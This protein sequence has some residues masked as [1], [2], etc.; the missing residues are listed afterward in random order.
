MF[1]ELSTDESEAVYL[2]DKV[3]YTKLYSDRQ[4]KGYEEFFYNVAEEVGLKEI[5]LYATPD[6]NIDDA[7]LAAQFDGSFAS[8]LWNST[9]FIPYPSGMGTRY[10]Q[11][12]INEVRMFG[13]TKAILVV[14]DNDYLLQHADE[15]EMVETF[16][17]ADA[18][19]A[20][21]SHASEKLFAD[22]KI[23]K[24]QVSLSVGGE[25]KENDKLLMLKAFIE[26]LLLVKTI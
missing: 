10:D 1:Q 26:A 5:S 25:T 20:D 19:I 11:K 9:A 15:N 8:F 7:K 23:I 18:V 14:T 12:I 16:N 21:I 13:D 17:M 6:M 22:A 4:M 24:L 2:F 3:Y